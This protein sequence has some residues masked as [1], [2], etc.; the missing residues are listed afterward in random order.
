[1]PGNLIKEIAEVKVAEGKLRFWWLG[2]QSWVIKSGGVTIFIDPYLTPKEKRRTQPFF[3]PEEMTCADLILGTHDHSDHIDRPSIGAMMQASPKAKLVVPQYPASTLPENGVPRERMLP[4]D[5]G[6]I[7][8]VCGVR[9]TAL[10]AR[11]EA[12]DYTRQFGFPYLQ[13]VIEINGKTV[14]TA[15]DTLLYDGMLSRLKMWRIDLAFVPING[16]DATRFARGCMGNM[17][18]QEAADF[19]G[20]LNPSLCCPAH[21]EMFADNAQD[22]KPFVDYCKVKYPELNYWVSTPGSSGEI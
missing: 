3:T 16:R 14:Y 13:Y 7:L 10:K 9:I 11:H 17:T 18:W 4:M 20:E 19:C 2:Q 1:M 15:G 12:F 22:P 5:D 21:Y 8:E 6:V